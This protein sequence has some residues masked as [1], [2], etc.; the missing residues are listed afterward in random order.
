MNDH[1]DDDEDD[2][3]DIDN[4]DDDNVLMTMMAMKMNTVMAH[5]PYKEVLGSKCTICV[6]K[7]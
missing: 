4:R 7:Q 5:V 1:D 2:D 3:N 6:P